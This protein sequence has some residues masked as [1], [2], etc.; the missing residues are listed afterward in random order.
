M[1][2]LC[3]PHLSLNLPAL[4]KTTDAFIEQTKCLN[5]GDNY[6]GRSNISPE[7]E[8]HERAK[9][10]MNLKK[11]MD[12]SLRYLLYGNDQYKSMLN[13]C[14]LE[15]GPTLSDVAPGLFK[16]GHYEVIYRVTRYI[17]RLFGRQLIDNRMY[18]RGVDLFP[19]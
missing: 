18:A 12:R 7:H 1:I 11:M 4:Y 14:T 19:R 16:P 3:S 10:Y 8:D 17:I 6:D 5:S 13:E 9:N 15:E 2:T